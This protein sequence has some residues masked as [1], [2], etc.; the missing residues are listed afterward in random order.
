MASNIRTVAQ[1]GE[2]GIEKGA[3][4]K[5]VALWVLQ[6]V[7]AALFLFA[8][9]MKLIT[10][11]AALVEQSKLPGDFL[12]F[13]GVAEILGGLGLVLP[14]IFR[15]WRILTPLA[16]A[17]LAIIMFGATILMASRGEAGMAIVPFVVGLLCSAVLR[18][19]WRNTVD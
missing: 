19:R 1:A 2:A 4:R 7:L 17:G 10:P 3:S 5:N 13:I 11:T 15:I 16:A 18:G 12:H 6:G 8:G 9:I 14:G